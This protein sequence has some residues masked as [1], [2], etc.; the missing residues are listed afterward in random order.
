MIEYGST[1]GPTG[2]LVYRK[3]RWECCFIRQPAPSKSRHLSAWPSFD[4]CRRQRRTIGRCPSNDWFRSDRKAADPLNRFPAILEHAPDWSDRIG[5]GLGVG[6][7]GFKCRSYNI[8]ALECDTMPTAGLHACGGIALRYPVSNLRMTISCVCTL[9]AGPYSPD[10]CL[11]NK[12]CIQQI[13]TPLSLFM[14]I[15]TYTHVS[16]PIHLAA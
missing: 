14:N 15:H 7:K 5:V 6:L 10:L 3:Q 9:L 16:Y 11:S 8:G 1:D 13:H 2:F 12:Q 4:L